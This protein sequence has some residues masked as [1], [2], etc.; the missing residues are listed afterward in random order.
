MN[1]ANEVD[2]A[3]VDAL[4]YAGA[5]NPVPAVAEALLA[6]GVGVNERSDGGMTALMLAAGYNQNPAVTEVLLDAG[7]DPSMRDDGGRTAWD[8]A[9]GNYVVRNAHVYRRLEVP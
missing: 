1:A 9:Q 6:A 2:T 5:N 3:G 8:Y 4:M 7:A